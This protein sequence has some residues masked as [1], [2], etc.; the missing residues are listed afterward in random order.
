M[1]NE[2]GLLEIADCAGHFAKSFK[3]DDEHIAKFLIP[4]ME[5]LDPYKTRCA[6]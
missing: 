4:H 3:K 2:A 1:H 5:M 6:I